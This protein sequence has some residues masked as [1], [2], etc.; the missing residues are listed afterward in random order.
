ME[1]D[2]NIAGFPLNED[3]SLDEL[4]RGRLKILQKKEGYR[5]SM[6]SVILARFARARPG[7]R[8]ID[9]GAGCGVISLI[10]AM[11]GKASSL[12]AVEIQE[13]LA[14]LA[15]RN[16]RI[17]K[18]EHLI[19]VHC[20]DV[21]HSR[22]LFP[23]HIFGLVVSNPPFRRLDAGTINPH[24]QK[25]LARHEIAGSLKAVLDASRYLLRHG[26]RAA[27]VYPARRLVHLL[28][29]LHA[30]GLEPRRLRMVHSLPAADATLVLVEGVRGAKEGL[31][32]LKPLLVYEQKGVYAEE[33]N[34]IL[35]STP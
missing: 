29:Q 12:D 2:R 10:M 34:Q 20:A 5:F 11:D 30:S 1:H 31:E 26:G 14:D 35:F 32:V 33:M 28:A 27:L 3:E 23:P 18:M 7:D 22:S 15:R 13:E 17:N 9:L 25:A 19:R 6:D 24:P 16:V 21:L 4:F 8:I